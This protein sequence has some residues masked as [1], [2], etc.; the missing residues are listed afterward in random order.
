[1]RSISCRQ[2]QELGLSDRPDFVLADSALFV[3]VFGE[4]KKPDATLEEIAVS[5]ERDDQIRRYLT[6]TARTGRRP[7]PG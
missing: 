6:P 7:W 3:G 1:V 2:G 4:I 5:T